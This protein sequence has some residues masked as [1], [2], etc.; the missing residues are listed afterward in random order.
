MKAKQSITATIALAAIASAWF[1]RQRQ[2]AV[3]R[4]REFDE[5]C[6]HAALDTFEGEGGLVSA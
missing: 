6:Q 5:K 4:E 3:R 2:N 1:T